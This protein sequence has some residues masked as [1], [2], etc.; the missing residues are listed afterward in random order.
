MVKYNK[1]NSIKYSPD[2]INQALNEFRNSTY[3]LQQISDKYKIKKSCLTYHC[4]Q[5]NKNKNENENEDAK[6]MKKALSEYD[7]GK[8]TQI[9]ICK[10]YNIKYSN[11]KY[12]HRR[13]KF[14]KTKQI[15]NNNI[16]KTEHIKLD[17]QEKPKKVDCVENNNI[18]KT[19]YIKLDEQ[20]KPKKVDCV[21]RKNI[22]KI[23]KNKVWN[24]H[25]GK[26]KGIGKCYV[27]ED[28]EIDSKHFECGHVLAVKDGGT[29][30]ITNLRPIC[31]ECNKCMGTMNL[32]DYKIYI[33]SLTKKN[34]P[35]P[36]NDVDRKQIL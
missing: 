33:Q 32:E 18:S 3:S 17:E 29:N 35:D 15:E 28:T 31:S 8:M 34:D 22:S 25:I 10:K 24:L 6:L 20:E 14:L 23:I 21:K 4:Y 16:S 7:T 27:C 2:L 1:E 5:V 36:D 13:Q 30:H 12:S 19:E 11:F 26:D 9:E